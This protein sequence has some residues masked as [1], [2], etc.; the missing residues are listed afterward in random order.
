VFVFWRWLCVGGCESNSQVFERTALVWAA[1]I[2][3]ADCARLLID[4]G[5]DKDAADKVRVDQCCTRG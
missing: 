4:I 1:V 3:K 2:G 5:A